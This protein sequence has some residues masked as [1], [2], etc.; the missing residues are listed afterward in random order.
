[1][2]KKKIGFHRQLMNNYSR[3]RQHLQK[4]AKPDAKFGDSWLFYGCRHRERDFL[5]RSV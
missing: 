2:Y 1:M 4:Q 3:Y 5:F